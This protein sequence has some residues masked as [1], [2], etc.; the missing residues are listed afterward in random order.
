[1]IAIRRRGIRC[2][3]VIRNPFPKRV[4]LALKFSGI[5]LLGWK[6]WFHFS[7]P[8]FF[9]TAMKRGCERRAS[10]AGSFSVPVAM[11]HAPPRPFRAN[12]ELPS[13]LPKGRK[14]TQSLAAIHTFLG[15]GAAASVRFV[16][17]KSLNTRKPRRPFRM[18]AIR[19]LWY[20]YFSPR[21]GDPFLYKAILARMES[22]KSSSPA[23]F[24]MANASSPVF[25]ASSNRPA[26]A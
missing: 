19:S 22:A 12:R 18:S 9:N 8:I 20:D 5:R 1:M 6:L 24:A 11:E 23:D 13:W 16:F 14:P 25:T 7:K 4:F 10:Q 17:A 2:G 21:K 26:F 15:P 3:S